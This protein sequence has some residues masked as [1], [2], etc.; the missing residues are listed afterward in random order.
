ML[1]K[2]GFQTPEMDFCFLISVP[3]GRAESFLLVVNETILAFQTK[4]QLKPDFIIGD[5]TGPKNEA[6]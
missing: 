3:F 1:Y 2:P 6:E 5:S 4:I